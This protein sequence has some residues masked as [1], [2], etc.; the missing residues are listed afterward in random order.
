[1]R[2]RPA[3]GS[4]RCRRR[5]FP[6]P[7]HALP[8]GPQPECRGPIAAVVGAEQREQSRV[9]R[10]G[11]VCPSQYAQPFGGKLNPTTLISARNGEDMAQLGLG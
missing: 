9:L 5:G 8:G 10:I 3:R 1:M 2:R 6:G 4:T 7:D 11:S